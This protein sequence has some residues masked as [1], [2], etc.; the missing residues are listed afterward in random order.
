MIGGSFTCNMEENT[1]QAGI[2]NVLQ[3]IANNGGEYSDYCVGTADEATTELGGEFMIR[4]RPRPLDRE[5]PLNP[6][7]YNAQSEPTAIM[8]RD[9]L[10][11]THGLLKEDSVGTGAHTHVFF[12]RCL[13]P[14][15]ESSSIAHFTHNKPR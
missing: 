3:F 4:P 7:Y 2:D 8:L 14:E 1:L 11:A 13:F 5:G 12:Y 6:Q 9:W 15:P 10:N